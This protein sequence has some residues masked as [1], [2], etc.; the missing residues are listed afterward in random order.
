LSYRRSL[1]RCELFYTIFS[2]KLIILIHVEMPQVNRSNTAYLSAIKSFSSF[3]FASPHLLNSRTE[4]N[5]I[6]RYIWSVN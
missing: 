4:A 5:N 3:F 1:I 6:Y 2:D